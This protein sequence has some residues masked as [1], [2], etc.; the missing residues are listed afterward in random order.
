MNLLKLNRETTMSSREIAELTGKDHDNVLR[1]IR[2]MREDAIGLKSEA[3]ETTYKDSIGRTLPAF[4]LTYHATMVLV[5]GYSVKL[6]AAVLKRWQELEHQQTQGGSPAL[7][8][9]PATEFVAYGAAMEWLGLNKNC[10]AIAANQAVVKTTG[11]DA[12]AK[13]RR[14]VRVARHRKAPQ[15]W[16][17]RTTTQ[18]E[19][20]HYQ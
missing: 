2:K 5:T 17:A 6:R 20:I 18:M 11:V 10:A 16:H 1:D 4:D 9:H 7:P 15:G 14:L 3:N 19:R 8:N 12:N 13:S